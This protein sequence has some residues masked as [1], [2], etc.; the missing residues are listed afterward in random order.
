VDAVAPE[1]AEAANLDRDHR[2]DAARA[3][4]SAP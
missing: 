1:E 3:A 2:S 4:A